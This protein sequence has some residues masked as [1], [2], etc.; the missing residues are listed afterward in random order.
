V[1][2]F[3]LEVLQYD[4]R[5]RYLELDGIGGKIFAGGLFTIRSIAGDEWPVLEAGVIGEVVMVLL[6]CT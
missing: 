3:D 1:A 4:Y 2:L 5:E 6:E